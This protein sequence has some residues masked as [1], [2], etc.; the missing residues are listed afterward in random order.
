M[1]YRELVKDFNRIRGYMRQFIAY[2]FR[3]REKFNQKSARSYDN[4][5]RRVESWLG[6]YMSFRRDKEGKVVFLSLDSRRIPR[7]PL[8][9]T[10]KAASFTKNDIS[11]HFILLDILADGQPRTL[12]GLLE[13]IDAEYLATFENAEPID[14][15]TLRKKL[16]EYAEIGLITA[17]KQGKQYLYAWPADSVNLENWRDALA[18]FAEENPLGVIGSFLLD[19]FAAPPDDVFAF[20]HRYLLFALD[21]GV[22]L[23]LLAAIHARRQV[24][25]TLVGGSNGAK[26]I[27]TIPLR[28][29]ISTQGGRQYLAAHSLYKK[30]LV[31]FRLDNIGKVKTL[32]DV[33]DYD[34]CQNRFA[35]SRPFIWGVATGQGRPERLVM[36]LAINRHDGHIVRRLERERRC[37]RVEF[38]G[39]ERWRFSAEVYDAA[40]LLPWLRTFI[41]RIV[42][43]TCT[44]KTIE[45]R[46]WA[47]LAA[48]EDL[49][50]GDGGVV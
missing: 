22:M 44:N 16:R 3:S 9:K 8:Y 31:F 4:E 45:A 39:G 5:K 25:L 26:R 14:L 36:E 43:L 46:F 34:A 21:N 40:E 10:W 7:N 12:A 2:G 17:Q 30:K 19:K 28:I 49:Y 24:E 13:T 38:L 6:A 33:P 35:E 11:L 27:V 29:F 32:A 47:D 37:G 41:G 18:F 20:K 1:A 50:G 23:E 48:L 42:S 15:S